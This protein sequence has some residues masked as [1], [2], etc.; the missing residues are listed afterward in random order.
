MKH[1]SLVTIT[2]A[3]LV[4]CDAGNTV[5][6]PSTH[7]SE[8]SDV[9]VVEEQTSA[10]HKSA[11]VEVR[12]EEVVAGLRA[13]T[14]TDAFKELPTGEDQLKV[15]CQRSG[16][17]RVRQTFCAE[18]PPAIKNLRDLQSALGLAFGQGSDPSF[19]LSGHSSSLVSRQVNSINPRAIIFTPP[20]GN[21]QSSPYVAL[22][23][24]RGE[25]FVE[26][27]AHDPGQSDNSKKL[28]FFL[29]RITLECDDN[30]KGCAA[31][32][33]LTP[34]IEDNWQGYTIY[35]DEDLKNTIFDCRVCHQAGGLNS[36]KML[37]MQELQNPWTHFMRSSTP[38]GQTLLREYTAAHG[39]S[40]T[41]AGIPGNRIN[42]T[43]PQ[44]LE[45]LVRAAGF[46]NQPNEFPTGQIEFGN[47]RAAWDKLYNRFASGEAI[48]PPYHGVNVS[49]PGQLKEMSDA[50]AAFRNG[51][52]EA[53]E[54]PDIRNT[55][56]PDDKWAMGFG[57]KPGSSAEQIL[58][59]ACAQ[60]HNGK[61]DQS[62]TRARFDV[63]LSKVKKQSLDEAIKRL[64][65]PE[66]DPK[67]MPPKRFRDLT[68]EEIKILSDHIKGA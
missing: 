47:N 17:D 50:Y 34:D 1:L 20:R 62:V 54:L 67:R 19:V 12:D 18:N 30:E 13:P 58:T 7:R 29:V 23:F 51:E 65:L 38:G 53:D 36:R 15:L 37:L 52:N 4:G 68:E 60:C 40:E 46:G 31:G 5:T 44:L 59:Q 8:K 11:D 24:V 10:E 43:D 55:F 66:D 41:Y 25:P 21:L 14:E 26:V 57:V 27:I 64:T 61:L 49:D 42:Q 2:I 28:K 16:S 45:N 6:S 32:S 35:E 63:D 22:G 56:R 33:L 3:M 9:S 48:P 39:S